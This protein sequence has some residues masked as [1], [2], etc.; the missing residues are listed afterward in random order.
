MQDHGSGVMTAVAALLAAIGFPSF[1]VWLLKSRVA[2]GASREALIEILRKA[3]DKG[4]VR[5]NAYCGALDTFI[6]AIDELEDPPASLVRARARALERL[7]LAH[8]QLTGGGQ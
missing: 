6:A 5:E 2:V 7:E 1:T 4:R 8:C 3:L